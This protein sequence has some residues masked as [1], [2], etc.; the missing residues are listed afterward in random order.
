MDFSIKKY[1]K[2]VEFLKEFNIPVYGLLDWHK[3]QPDFGVL[4]E[5]HVD[6]RSKNS[7]KIA[8]IENRLTICSTFFYRSSKNSFKP[9]IVSEVSKLGHEIG[10]H[11]ND[12]AQNKG[13]IQLTKQV[14]AA[15]LKK[16]RKIS[17]IAS[18]AMYGKPHGKFDSRKMW[19]HFWLNDFDL[20]VE[21]YMGIDYSDIY[22]FA[23]T[24]RTWSCVGNNVNDKVVSNRIADIKTTDDLI[25]F[26]K[27]NRDKKIAVVTHPK[28]W[29]D[30]ILEHFYI[31]FKDLIIRIGKKI[32]MI[33]R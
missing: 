15:N 7:L 5:H 28:R 25:A 30:G 11:Y 21:A 8:E 4:L 6:K 32:L 18:V 12:Y 23:D 1:K 10:Y 20:K 13:N 16:F 33:F 22:Y 3:K 17:K 26:I 29:S 19:E 2:F 9:E 14:F 27:N 31:Y 24:G